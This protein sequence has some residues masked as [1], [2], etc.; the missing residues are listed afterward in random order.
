[1]VCFSF[2][3]FL[4]AFTCCKGGWE[5]IKSKCVRPHDRWSRVYR[6]L[7][8]ESGKKIYQ[9]LV[10]AF[11]N[12][13]YHNNLLKDLPQKMLLRGSFPVLKWC[14]CENNK[15]VCTCFWLNFLLWLWPCTKKRLDRPKATQS[16]KYSSFRFSLFFKLRAA[17]F[18]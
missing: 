4:Y 18:H 17:I 16:F 3:M 9:T 2:R 5:A 8:A 14:L 15:L 7:P 11:Q 13:S 12:F 6:L 1:M 10:W